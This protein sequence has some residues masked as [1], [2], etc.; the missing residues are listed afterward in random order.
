MIIGQTD[1]GK[2]VFLLDL[3]E[4]EYKN[5]FHYDNNSMSNSNEK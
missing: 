5:H 4:N 3:L 1:S 2:T